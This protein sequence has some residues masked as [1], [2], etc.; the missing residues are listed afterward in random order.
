MCNKERKL[1][2]IFVKIIK[3]QY[4][5]VWDFLGKYFEQWMGRKD[6]LEHEIILK[7][8]CRYFQKSKNKLD[9]LNDQVITAKTVLTNVE[10][11]KKKSER[12]YNQ[13]Y[14][15][16]ED[17][18]AELRAIEVLNKEGFNKFKCI[19][20]ESY[21]T[22][23]FEVWKND[24]NAIVEVKHKHFSDE[25]KIFD[26]FKRKLWAESIRSK[27][28]RK[29][30][31]SNFQKIPV[32]FEKLLEDSDKWNTFVEGLKRYVKT[33]KER[34]KYNQIEIDWLED[35]I[36]FNLSDQLYK[37]LMPRPRTPVNKVKKSER[38]EKLYDIIKNIVSKAVNQI[39]QYEK[40]A[41][42]K[43]DTRYVIC[44]VK[45]NFLT[46]LF[47]SSEIEKVITRLKNAF[48]SIH[49]VIIQD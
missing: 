2:K 48:K 44:F 15:Q 24:V 30:F 13:N 6:W 27:I 39:E 29:S 34:Y 19:K 43:F 23:E 9:Y 17:W 31:G 38:I 7:V 16:W 4:P 46:A 47:H 11:F 28:L 35:L 22:P 45:L 18:Y 26:E 37:S 33:G 42:R 20:E 14:S 21:P 10:D 1:K 36:E 25:D 32:E 8:F 3:K 12:L 49:V 5:D 40:T 41:T